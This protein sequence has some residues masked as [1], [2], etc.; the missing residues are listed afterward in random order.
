MTTV[1]GVRPVGAPAT[2]RDP[3]WARLLVVAGALLLVISGA[4]MVGERFLVA[5]YTGSVTQRQFGGAAAEQHVS[6]NGEINLLLVGVDE[7]PDN[8]EPV[9]SDSIIVMHV[10]EN[11]DKAYLIPIPRDTYTKIP[12]FKDAGAKIDFRGSTTKINA[13]YAFGGGTKG[14]GFDL[15]AQTVH[16]LTG[17]TF[18]GGAVVN[19]EGFRDIVDAL[20]GV[21][22]V[23]DEKVTSIHIGKDRNGNN[24]HPAY[25]IHPDGTVG[26]LRPGI[27]PIVYLP[28]PHHFNGWQALDYCRQRDLLAKG[29][30]DYGRQR[31]QVQFLRAMAKGVQ[32][33]GVIS[34]PLKLDK[35]LRATGKAFTFYGQGIKLEDWAYALK[36]VDSEKITT[37]RTNGGQFTTKMVD[38]QSVQLFSDDSK[39][40]FAD[41]RDGR[42][43]DF[44]AQHPD[45]V[46]PTG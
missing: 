21:D 44:L 39:Q 45:W 1:R 42:L 36:G 19:F 15:L 17:M 38:G 23:V 32:S 18:S 34:D 13:A 12:P 41:L 43:D 4:A 35:V 25:D 22:M 11:H 7:R 30:G 26:H 37:I 8:N 2:R 46:A 9:R 28:G 5:R 27:T 10:T 33:Q 40:L 24:V 16:D 3:L 14:K 20:G 29:D 6:I 31:H